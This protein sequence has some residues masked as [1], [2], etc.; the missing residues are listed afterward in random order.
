MRHGRFPA[1]QIPQVPP[2]GAPCGFS[3]SNLAL[4]PVLRLHSEHF[5]WNKSKYV[6]ET[7]PGSRKNTSKKETNGANT[8]KAS[9][10][11]EKND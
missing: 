5:P 1:T 6:S 3:G 10:K 9:R 7:Y 8:K 4:D 2:F 11:T